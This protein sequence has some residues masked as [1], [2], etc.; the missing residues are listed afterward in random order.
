MATVQAAL[1]LY[2]GMTQPLMSIHRA[3]NIVLNTFQAMQTASS[4]SIDVSAIQEAREELARAGAAMNQI[5]SNVSRGVVEQQ[6]FN[7]NI[8]DG[9]LAADSLLSKFKGILAT[10]MSIAGIKMAIN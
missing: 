2:D 1:A 9:T 7:Q 10:V 3:L 5:E 8:R 4:R 6:S